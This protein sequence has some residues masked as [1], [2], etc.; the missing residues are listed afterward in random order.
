MNNNKN[1]AEV[2]KS[3]IKLKTKTIKVKAHAHKTVIARNCLDICCIKKV[4]LSLRDDLNA[5]LAHARQI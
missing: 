2:N 3:K 4:Y 1:K 5:I